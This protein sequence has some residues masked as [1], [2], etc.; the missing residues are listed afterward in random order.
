MQKMKIKRWLLYIQK[1]KEDNNNPMLIWLFLLKSSDSQSTILKL[2]I[3]NITST[4]LAIFVI[5]LSLFYSNI[6]VYSTYI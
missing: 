5:F 3:S 4:S 1:I 6:I 2:W